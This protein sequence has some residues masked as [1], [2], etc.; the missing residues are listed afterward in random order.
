ME[1]VIGD[2]TQQHTQAVVNAAN[3]QLRP[4]AGV[5]G[6]IYEAAGKE[7]N[8]YL[9]QKDNK[10]DH[11]DVVITPAFNM[12]AEYIIHAIG[13]IFD[14]EFK[15]KSDNILSMVYWNTMQA[16]NWL[17]IDSVAIPALSTGIYGFPEKRAAKIAIEEIEFFLSTHAYPKRIVCV[18]YNKAT[19]KIYEEILG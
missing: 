11:G 16:C 9:K 10:A 12:D 1:L 17:M 18:C 2:I 15:E 4:G 14:K 6:A 13:P 7:L 3:P 8:T 19:R 5:C